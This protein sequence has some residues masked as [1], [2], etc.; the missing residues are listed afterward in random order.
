MAGMTLEKTTMTATNN[1]KN[2]E[3]NFIDVKKVLLNP[4]NLMKNSKG[5][6]TQKDVIIYQFDLYISKDYATTTT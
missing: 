1:R 3:A 5:D 6:T 2:V 4:S